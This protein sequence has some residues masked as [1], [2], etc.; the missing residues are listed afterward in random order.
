MYNV[1][2]YVIYRQLQA[3]KIDGIETPSFESDK[4]KQYYKLVPA[5]ED[6][7]STTI[8][9]PVDS[10][11]SLRPL[12][13]KAKIEEALAALPELTPTVFTAKKP[14]QLTA[15]YQEILLSTDILRYL[16]LVKEVSVKSKSVKRLNEIDARYRAKTERLLCEEFALVLGIS[17]EDAQEKIH[18]LL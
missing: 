9:V 13:S 11:D 7:S 3:C 6:K 15:H 16:L 17:P 1:N 18:A 4:T 10:K 12:S 2:D 14:P 5:F 8:Y